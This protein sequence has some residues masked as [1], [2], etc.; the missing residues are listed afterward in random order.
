M[1]QNREY[2]AFLAMMEEL[3]GGLREDETIER[4]PELQMKVPTKAVPGKIMGTRK[5]QKNKGE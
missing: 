3:K 5:Q 4:R 1:N 2:G